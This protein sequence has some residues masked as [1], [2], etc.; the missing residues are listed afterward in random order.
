MIMN[1]LKQF[2]DIIDL[3]VRYKQC[4]RCRTKRTEYR[5]CVKQ[6]SETYGSYDP[7]RNKKQ[8]DK[9]RKKKL[10]MKSVYAV[11]VVKQ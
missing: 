7:N 6:Q 2:L 5:K 9:I 8:C 1:M 11:C 4:V 3:N 10:L